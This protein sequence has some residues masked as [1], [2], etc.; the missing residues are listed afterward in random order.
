MLL[1]AQCVLFIF[2]AVPKGEI[3]KY[4]SAFGLRNYGTLRNDGKDQLVCPWVDIIFMQKITFILTC[5]IF[6]LI[7][8]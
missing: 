6:L 8:D 4:F 3:S 5:I 1:F 2:L 7:G